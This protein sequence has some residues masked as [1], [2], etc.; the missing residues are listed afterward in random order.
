MLRYLAHGPRNFRTDP[1]PPLPRYN[2]EFYAVLSGTCAPFFSEGKSPNMK[3]RAL[4]VLKPGSVHGWKGNGKPI[5]RVVFHFASVPPD[6]LQAMGSSTCL[7]V[8]LEDGDDQKIRDLL[9]E[10]EPHL[11]RPHQFSHLVFERAV[12]DL[13]IIALKQ[14]PLR[15]DIPLSQIASER[16]ERALAWYEI[17]MARSPT[18]IDVAGAVNTTPTHLRRLF[19]K[20]KETSP[21][22]AF[23]KLQL[24]RATDLLST[25]QQTLDEIA[26]Q[27]GFHST[28]D[29][30]RVFKQEIGAT[31]NTWRRK[32][33]P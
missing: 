25:T 13:T 15:R 6:L 3:D 30:A 12:L 18:T 5:D 23:R 10:L 20:V 4:W 27:C 8:T 1:V 2:W 11:R 31:A 33:I 21:H 17:N 29:F 32:I 9:A 16:V 22:A 24:K 26:P 14:Q 28:T 7:T 19:K